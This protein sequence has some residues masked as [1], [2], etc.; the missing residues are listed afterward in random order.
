MLKALIVDDE[1][2]FRIELKK[3]IDWSEYQIEIVGEAENGRA[4]IQFLSQHE[5]DIIISDLSMPGLSGIEFLKTV[6]KQFP[7]VHIVVITMHKNFEFIQQAM[8]IGAVDYITK[9]QIEKENLG[10]IIQ[11]II[12]RLSNVPGEECCVTDRISVVLE[13]VPETLSVTSEIRKLSEGI[14]LV[15]SDMYDFP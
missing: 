9:T 2:L 11:N 13:L 3:L 8:R 7:K 12:K 1:K 14:W 4:A 6:R 15:P 5:V 10:V